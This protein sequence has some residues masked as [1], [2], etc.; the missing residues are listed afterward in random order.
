MRETAGPLEGMS[1]TWPVTATPS[2][3]ILAAIARVKVADMR[4]RLAQ[5]L[6]DEAGVQ[7]AYQAILHNLSVISQAV[8]SMPADILERYPDTPWGEIVEL[9]DVIGNRY[10]RIVPADIHQMVETYL[11]PL[12][13]T[14]RRIRTAQKSA[15]S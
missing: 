7:M 4:M 2:D 14:A 1:H 11:D 9:P 12:D 3:D 10:H 5:S 6:V 13:V 8:Q 15:G